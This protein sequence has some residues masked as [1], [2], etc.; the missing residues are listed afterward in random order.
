MKY[1]LVSGGVV[2]GL[3]KGITASSLGVLLKGF[4]L[5][6]TCI[7]IDPY[8]NCD[9]GTMSPFEHG[10]VYVLDD[11]GEVDLDMGNYERFLDVSLTKDHNI[12][13][14][15]IYKN[16]LDKERR[17][18][19]LGKTVQVFP[20]ITDEV[21]RWI[22][23]VAH[24]PL[25]FSGGSGPE[26]ADVCIIE[27]GGTIGDIESGVFVEAL[28]QLEAKVGCQNFVCVLVSFV[29]CVVVGGEQKSK[30]TQQS[31]TTLR[32]LGL[33]PSIV[34]CRCNGDWVSEDVSR[35]IAKCAG[36]ELDRVVSLPDV[37]GGNLWN[38]PLIMESQC[39]H[40]MLSDLLELRPRAEFS[41]DIWR[42]RIASQWDKLMALDVGVDGGM[43]GHVVRIGIVG[44]YTGNSDAYLSIVKGLQHAC[45]KE[46]LKLEIKWIEST[47][48]EEKD[49]DAKLVLQGLDGVLIPGGF[50]SR[51]VE[52]MIKACEYCR[53]SG[54]PFFGICL[55]M[56]VAV[57]EYC[58]N[59]L[60]IVNANSQEFIEEGVGVGVAE[61][62]VYPV[63]INMPD[64]S[65]T[66]LGGTMRLGLQGTVINP[67]SIAYGLYQETVVYERHRHRYEVHPLLVPYL[68]QGGITVTG[69][70]ERTKE[71]V[72]IIELSAL[73]HPF[74]V[75]CQFH[76]EYKTRPL[77]PSPL[78][79]GF[80][81]AIKSNKQGKN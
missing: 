16:V 66:D 20:H 13:T 18:C 1:V 5:K 48:L 59:V 37:K 43:R 47:L 8:L 52:G 53:V 49:S 7:K 17:G 26:I 44:K 11:G 81:K 34:A 72:E 70:D 22:E 80:V 63:I 9:A 30:P 51:G 55:G 31:I 4:G 45:M 64:H 15:K 69:R 67:F 19:Y 40:L 73:Q 58:R 71:R 46:C 33:Y 62:E 2:S 27:L 6:V 76:P 78:F 10:E 12:T 28:R 42:E 38:V 68:Q 57:I 54:V 60:G 23:E 41:L 32:S 39:V 14:G 50:G 77:K 61:G 29:P 3:G 36:I 74:Y 75:A 35:K 56:Q 65:D 24:K 79:L 21:L 25:M